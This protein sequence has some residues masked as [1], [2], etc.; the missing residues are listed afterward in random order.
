MIGDVKFD[1][2]LGSGGCTPYRLRGDPTVFFQS[3]HPLSAKQICYINLCRG[4]CP[5]S[6][7]RGAL[8]AGS[9]HR[10]GD[11]DRRSADE[12]RLQEGPHERAAWFHDLIT[13]TSGAA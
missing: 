11:Q 12:S 13:R 3:S 8:S 1:T 2:R 4:I 7:D 9:A 10:A 5:S 6:K